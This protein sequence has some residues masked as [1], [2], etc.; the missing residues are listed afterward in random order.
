MNWDGYTK[1]SSLYCAFMN[2]TKCKNDK[3]YYL[4]LSD[5]DHEKVQKKVKIINGLV[6]QSF[7]MVQWMVKGRKE[8]KH[9]YRLKKVKSGLYD[10]LIF[11]T[12]VK[13]SNLEYIFRRFHSRYEPI[14]NA[15]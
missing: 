4:I 3:H 15:K 7:M 9:I 10:R 2:Y 1:N 12:D 6:V 8:F 5:E 11:K 13:T 14:S